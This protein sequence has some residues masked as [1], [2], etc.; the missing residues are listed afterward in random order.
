[1]LSKKEK[2]VEPQKTLEASNKKIFLLT[3]GEVSNP[4]QVINLAR[5]SECR[6]HSFGVGRDCSKYLVKEVA[7]AGRG[8]SSFIV[9]AEDN[10]KGKVIS[11]LRKAT[12]ASLKGCRFT[13]ILEGQAMMAVPENGVIGEAFRNDFVEEYLV[14]TRAQFDK[15]RAVFHSDMDPVSKG[16]IDVTIE[17]GDFKILE[18]GTSLFKLA[19][20]KRAK[21][22][23]DKIAMS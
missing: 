22:L 23:Y 11:A 18:P 1:M 7:K 2:R 13:H 9:D 19:A 6:V 21:E 10:M 15:L 12:E 17:S 4:E 14:L 3:D 20:K 8:S 16:P 5:N